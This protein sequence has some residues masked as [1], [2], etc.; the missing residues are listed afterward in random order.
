MTSHRDDMI[1]LIRQENEKTFRDIGAT[2][3]AVLSNTDV[4]DRMWPLYQKAVEEYEEGPWLAMVQALLDTWPNRPIENQPKTKQL[5]PNE[6]WACGFR[7]N[8][9]GKPS[10]DLKPTLGVKCSSRWSTLEDALNENPS[11]AKHYFKPYN[12]NRTDL[13]SKRYDL[14]AL[15]TFKN[16]KACYL[17]YNE[18]VQA[19][20]NACHKVLNMLHAKTIPD[21]ILDRHCNAK[22]DNT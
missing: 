4:L 17:K 11:V 5:R 8:S 9:K 3:N 12:K 16:D 22:E 21:F 15:H 6:V 10:L 20:I 1:D 19:N 13:V 14:I 2:K 7:L 18:L